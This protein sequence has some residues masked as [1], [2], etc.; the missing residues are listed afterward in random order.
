V[1]SSGEDAV[2]AAV[3]GG[4]ATPI[5]REPE[6]ALLLAFLDRPDG[7]RALAL[8]GG[9]GIGKT[10]LW[11]AAIA[12]ARGSGC[13]VLAAR[14]SGAEARLAFAAVIDLL[15][16]VG[17]DEL[18]ALPAP[19]RR[20]LDVVVLRADPIGPPPEMRAIALGL[21]NVLRGAAG[22]RPLVIA[23]DD[24]QW[25]DP[26]SLDV[27]TFVARR[28]ETPAVRYLLSTRPGRASPLEH[29]IGPPVAR[30]D[31]GPL[32][33][34]A[35]R[36]LL[37]DRLGLSLPRPLL[38]RL[39]DSTMGNPLFALEV[40][41]TLTDGELPGVGDDLPV[42]DTVEDLLGTRVGRLP[43]RVRRLLLA[44][45]LSQDPTV[46]QLQ[47]IADPGTLDEAV[48]ASI[49]VLDG[50]RVRAA[51]PL[52]AAAAKKR[53]RPAAR[54]ELHFE[55]SRVVADD[56]LRARH[57]ALAADA[58]DRT[59]ARTIAAAADA[60][61]A[62]GAWQA[63]AELGE[64][65]LRLTP[66]DD[67]ERPKRA[68]DVG[69]TLATVGEKQ[70]LAKL[71]EAELEPLPPGPDRARLW[72]LMPGVVDNN[73]AILEYFERALDESRSDPALHAAVLGNLSFN[74]TAIRVEQI[75][76]AEEWAEQAL[77][78]SRA[79]PEIERSVLYALAKARGLR[80]RPFDD[81]C[82]RFL[83]ISDSA[84]YILAWPERI[85]GLRLTW[86]G[87]LDDARE[88]FAWLL[89]LAEERGDVQGY[90]N[91]RIHSCDLELRAGL[92]D[93][94]SQ[95]LEDWADPAEQELIVWPAFERSQAN[96]AAGRGFAA[97][98][99]RWAAEELDR[100]RSNRVPFHELEAHR[101]LGLASLVAHEPGAAVESL[102]SVWEHAERVGVEEPG[103]FPV[104]PDLVEALVEL[105]GL[106][107]A[108][109][110]TGRLCVLSKDQQHPWGL[111][112]AKRCE[113]TI[114]LATGYGEH[115]V[116]A[117]EQ[118][119]A[120]YDLL[121]LRFDRARSLLAL[122][123]GQRRHRKWGAARRTLEAAEA[124]FTAMGSPG[125]AEEARTELARV[126]ARRPQPS[127][128]LT[129]AERRVAE[130]A[131]DGLANKEIAQALFVS[132]K[133]V[134]GH[135]SHVYAKL[136]VR[137]RAQLARRLVQG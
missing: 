25:L 34:G 133:T 2:L 109:R 83:A 72:L 61:N 91:V 60:A 5:G 110:V 116:R 4:R 3:T 99:K 30:L 102:R 16:D 6:L 82:E 33:L 129:P 127:G 19:Q 94:A 13:R 87:E 124:A 76:E 51:H 128:E 59:L 73:D 41:R 9:P 40:G 57:L 119:A 123:R 53:S 107:E 88:V 58:P 77:E 118:A 92:W 39:V 135:L 32:S 15:D 26:H 8:Y 105:G 113:G 48:E 49:L 71:L 23:I 24:V 97:E 55:L 89:A 81:L 126:G 104:A 46:S 108:T 22:A 101:I 117:L 137:S 125:W 11:E 84:T 1:L 67:P 132:V 114:A 68:F 10:T 103:L 79:D 115:A 20:A 78:P 80:G 36:Q 54:R 42:P 37:H 66:A 7:A 62:R 69:I 44:V 96:L 29:A 50:H 130:L 90:A 52:I 18:D 43:E 56:E 14:A 95:L 12:V 64:H 38:R 106:D 111:A 85:K 63:A 75:R 136:G 47:A 86:R 35:T 112:T 122:G 45:A 31:V 17:A 98:A 21:L 74:A 65:A 134:E 28:L 120:E 27:L 93:R 100:A 70:R 131:G 121:G